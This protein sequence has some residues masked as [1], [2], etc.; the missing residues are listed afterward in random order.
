M[1]CFPRPE[2]WS[3]S[4]PEEVL[5]ERVETDDPHRLPQAIAASCRRKQILEPSVRPA[6][7]RCRARGAYSRKLAGMRRAGP[8][9][10]RLQQISST[11]VLPSAK[12]RCP[13]QQLSKHTTESESVRSRCCRRNKWCAKRN[14][15]SSSSLPVSWNDGTPRA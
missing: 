10:M 7:G 14:A 2:G 13:G 15:Q 4:G 12:Y 9:R 5:V 3:H 8:R 1:Q 6:V 11:L